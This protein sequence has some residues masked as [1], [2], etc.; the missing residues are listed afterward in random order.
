MNESPEKPFCS[1][2][3]GL[4][5]QAFNKWDVVPVKAALVQLPPPGRSRVPAEV[6]PE[7]PVMY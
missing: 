4:K 3:G 1:I 7:V 2:F 6:A 5:I